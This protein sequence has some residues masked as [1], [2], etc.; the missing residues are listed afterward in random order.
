MLD[1]YGL[2]ENAF[3][4]QIYETRQMWV[5][6]YFKDVFCARMMSTRRSESAN[7]MLKNII[8]PSCPLHQFV[9]QY[10]KMQY[11]RDEDENYQERRNKLVHF[12]FFAKSYLF[13]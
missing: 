11:I 12:Y 6:C 7:H 5:K 2:S 4:L 1:Q 8:S 10:S 13:Q 3:L 9:Q